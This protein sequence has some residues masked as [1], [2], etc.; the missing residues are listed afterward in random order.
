MTDFITLACPSCGAKLEITNDLG[1]FACSHCGQEHMV[2]RGGGIVS[3][4][5]VV[6]AIH[7]VQ[8]GVDRT[9]AELALQRLPREKEF[10]TS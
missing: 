6:G 7:Q 2:R 4:S 1:R 10:L 5:P 3:L 9:A 8:K